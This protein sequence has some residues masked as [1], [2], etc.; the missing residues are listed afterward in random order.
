LYRFDSAREPYAL[1]TVPVEDLVRHNVP[2]DGELLLILTRA[3]N[4]N[5]RDGGTGEFMWSVRVSPPFAE[6]FHEHT[7]KAILPD[8][9]TLRG[10]AYVSLP[11]EGRIADIDLE[12]RAVV[13]TFETG[14]EPTRLILIEAGG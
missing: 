13:G 4:L 10:H 14:G 7:D 9:L 11:N 5:V 2:D 1:E 6:D 3:G 12:K 8:I